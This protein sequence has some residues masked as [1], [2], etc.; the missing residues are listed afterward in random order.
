MSRIRALFRVALFSYLADPL[1]YAASLLTVLFCAFRFFFAG[2][3][4]VAGLGSTSMRPFFDSVP[5]ISILVAPLLALRLRPLVLDD[6][7]PVPPHER[8]LS[9]SAAAFSALAFPVILLTAVPVC[10]GLFGTVDF[11]QCAAGFLGIL[12]HGFSSVS[13]C[14]FLFAA[15][16]F[17]AAVPL[18]LSA[19]V[20]A[21][22]NS[23]HLLPLYFQTGDALAFLCRS[24]SF[25]WHFDSFS[26]GIID[27]R[28]LVYYA[29]VPLSLILLA[30]L[31]ECRRLGRRTPRLTVFL[32]AAVVVVISLSGQNLYFRADVTRSRQFSVS[33]T[34]RRI[35]SGLDGTLRITYFRSAELKSLYPQTG[36]VAEFLSDFASAGRNVTLA[37]EKADPARLRSLGVQAQQIRRDNGTKTEFVSVYSA[38]L[39]QYFDESELIPFVLSASNLE[40]DLAQRVSS[41]VTRRERR[42]YIL[43]GNGR[44]VSESYFYVRPW[45]A[46]RGFSAEEIEGYDAD[47]VIQG[48]SP[49]DELVI[50]GTKDLPG[51]TVSLIQ[52]AL[53]RGARAFIA[54]SPFHTTVEDEWRVSRERG[55]PMLSYLN[56]QGFAFDNSLV[57]DISCFPLTMESSAD[58]S[59]DAGTEFVTTNYPLWVAIQNQ[60]EAV[61]GVT[62]FWASPV[63]PYGDVEPL[64][65]TTSLAWAQKSALDYGSDLFLTNPFTLPKTAA[66]SGAETAQFVVAARSESISLVSDQFFVSSLMTGFISGESGG[67]FRN[68]DY[69]AK[70]LLVLRGE[71]ELA[72]LM[73]KSAPVTSLHKLTGESSFRRAM[74]AAV[75]VNFVI[76]PLAVIVLFVAVQTRRRRKVMRGQQEE[77]R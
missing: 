77:T 52:D 6:S 60:K 34:S 18:I 14:L 46:A 12:L 64:L 22:V 68:Y 61:R 23:V 75:T 69:L 71:T 8:F 72:A 57:E 15:L 41:L 53:A 45:L 73:D 11:S 20:L 50:L 31:A 21:L 27:S 26:K 1:F 5:Y 56:A 58:G 19:A 2:K 54:A 47:G 25:A 67:D 30:A 29:A 33:D 16:A 36:D 51:G 43:C 3:F 44:K 35:L 66:A 17:S 28:N 55:D 40:Y 48:L 59:Y 62:V 63:V 4:F 65:Y 9:L 70:E 76:L 39:L 42:V 74:A 13:L 24:L 38:V 32:T 49:G 37:L 10:A 7:L